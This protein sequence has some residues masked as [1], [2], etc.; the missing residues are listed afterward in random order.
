MA[1]KEIK[2]S[3]SNNQPSPLIRNVLTFLIALGIILLL[4]AIVTL[5]SLFVLILISIVF[6]SGLAPGMLW[7]EKLRLPR[8][9]RIPRGLAI[10]LIYIFAFVVILGAI[11]LI[12]VPVVQESIQFYNHLPSYIDNTTKWFH[13]LQAKHEW[14]PDL[15]VLFKELSEKA[16]SQF[17]EIGGY[18]LSSVGVAFG[19]L[20]SVISF[21]TVIVL[22]F[23]ILSSFENMKV[24]FLSLIP[25]RHRH[26]TKETLSEMAQAMGGWLRGQLL[27]A[28]IVGASTTLAMAAIGLPYAAV[29]GVIGAVAELIP[30]V[31]PIAALI[32]AFLIALTGPV[33][34]LVVIV[35][36][37]SLLSSVE[38]NVLA[39]RIMQKSV[40]I[41][42]LVTIIAL[43]AGAALLGIV[44]ALLAIPVAAA[45]QVFVNRIVIPA[46]RKRAD[47]K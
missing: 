14:L 43:L 41:S 28:G 40:G 5:K 33:W 46:L 13:S 4:W 34:K 9:R 12:V 20:G 35:I 10:L 36:F 23:Y 11:T 8:G 27:L 6:A 37:F 30:M 29:I 26:I 47:Q 7:L 21:I 16:R 19:F 2:Q 38:S 39:P 3:E 45:I 32:P 22:T 18:L 44:G 15:P 25:S 31:G 42:P 17:G 24:Q 1:A